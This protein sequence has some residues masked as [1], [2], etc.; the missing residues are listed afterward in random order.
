MRNDKA[1]A[2]FP[3]EEYRHLVDDIEIAEAMLYALN[4]TATQMMSEDAASREEK[5]L[6]RLIDQL[7]EHF[8]QLK[9]RAEKVAT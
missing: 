7:D 2:A 5:I 1:N 4:S 3:S 9:A 6:H 8:G